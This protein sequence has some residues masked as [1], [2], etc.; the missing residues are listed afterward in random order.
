MKGISQKHDGE[1][2]KMGDIHRQ[3]RKKERKKEKE[4]FCFQ[5]AG[6]SKLFCVSV[7]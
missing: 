5:I 7:D 1:K 6:T 4:Q 3:K 2:K